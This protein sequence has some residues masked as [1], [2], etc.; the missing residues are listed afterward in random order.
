M[1]LFTSHVPF[2]LLLLY[3]FLLATNTTPKKIQEL[4]AREKTQTP[5]YEVGI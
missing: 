2:L 4:A 1:I 3:N 5:T